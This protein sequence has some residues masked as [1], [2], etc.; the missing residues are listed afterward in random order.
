MRPM[1]EAGERAVGG[2]AGFTTN[3]GDEELQQSYPVEADQSAAEAGDTPVGWLSIIEN[4][5]ASV[6]VPIAYVV[7]ARP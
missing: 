2:G 5:A 3:A 7:C 4:E 1:C 6:Q